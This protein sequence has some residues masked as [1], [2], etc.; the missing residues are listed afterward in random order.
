VDAAIKYIYIGELNSQLFTIDLF[1]FA[2]DHNIKGLL[3]EIQEY[4]EN[5]INIENA[6]DHYFA[7]E[8]TNS[9]VLRKHCIS[10]IKKKLKYLKNQILTLDFSEYAAKDIFK[11]RLLLLSSELGH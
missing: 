4:F 7:A 9:I 10:F 5:N 3:N 6:I 1:L 11:M 2:Y 8:K